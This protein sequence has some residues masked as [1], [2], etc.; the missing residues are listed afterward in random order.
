MSTTIGLDP[1]SVSTTAEFGINSFGDQADKSF[2][3]VKF[4]SAVGEAGEV[5]VIANDGLAHPISTTTDLV[6]RRV[7]IAPDIVPI[8]SYCWL[9]VRGEAQFLVAANCAAHTALRATAVGGVVDDSG[10]GPVI[11]GIVNTVAGGSMQGLVDGRLLHP[12]LQV[13]GAGGGGGITESEGD[14]RYLQLTGGTV[15]DTLFVIPATNKVALFLDANA[16]TSQTPFVFSMRPSGN[17]QAFWI[18]RGSDAQAFFTLDGNVGGGNSMPGIALGPGGSTTRDVLLYRGGGNILET[19]DAFRAAT[20][21]LGTGTLIGQAAAARLATTQTNLGIKPIPDLTSSDASKHVTVNT[22]GDALEFTDPPSGTVTLSDAVPVVEGTAVAG[23]STEVSRSDHVH[24]SGG[25]GGGGLDISAL[26]ALD[27]SN[28]E[29]DD[30]FVVYDLDATTN[31][32]MSPAE[33]FQGLMR[34]NS[35]K[36]NPASVAG[37]DQFA[38]LDHSASEIRHLEWTDLQGLI[39]SDT[40]PIAPGTAAAGDGTE[41]SRDNHVHAKE[42][43]DYAADDA[44]KHVAINATG[45]GV[46]LTVPPPA[47]VLEVL[48]EDTSDQGIRGDHVGELYSHKGAC[49]I[50]RSSAYRNRLQGYGRFRHVGFFRDP[51]RHVPSTST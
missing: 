27:G 33:M 21:E 13:Q 4:N 39:L 38:L 34:R 20:L 24:P 15:T 32:K 51:G 10:T 23:T 50:G 29:A 36:M 1:N 22:A 19:P 12:T 2:V 14:A 26:T 40:V 6:G 35:V 42:L 8:N 9:L 11:E 46:V 43:P 3:Y 17:Q 5:C 49:R 45:T 48:H 37:S 41:A 31:K 28:L 25:G 30:E 18:R 44:N 7:G 16:L 47:A